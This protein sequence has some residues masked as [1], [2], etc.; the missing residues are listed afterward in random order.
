MRE[1]MDALKSTLLTSIEIVKEFSQTCIDVFSSVGELASTVGGTQVPGAMRLLQ[2][3][4]ETI[5]V[6]FL[7]F[8]VVAITMFTE[9]ATTVK[10][11]VSEVYRAGEIIGAALTLDWDNITD[12]WQQGTIRGEKI[13]AEGAAKIKKLMMETQA[14]IDGVLDHSGANFSNEGRGRKPP[15][16]TGKN[17]TPPAATTPPPPPPKSEVGEW[18]RINKE[19]KDSFEFN[20]DLKTRDLSNDVE[21]WQSKLA[22]A[23]TTNGDLLRV[24]EKLAAARLAVL[25]KETADGKA[26]TEVAIATSEK[27]ALDGLAAAKAA[28]DSEF[29]MGKITQAQ[30]VAL[31]Q[32]AEDQKFQILK[33]HQQLR[34]RL[35]FDDPNHTAAALQREKD[36]LLEIERAHESAVTAIKAKAAIDD[37]KYGKQFEDGMN[38]GFSSVIKNFAQGTMTIQSL[39]L[40]MGK[41]VLSALTDVFAQIAA[42]WL[43][44]KVMQQVGAKVSSMAQIMGSAAAAGAAAFASTAAIPIVGPELAPAAAAAAYSGASSFAA[45]PG[46][47]VG[48]WNI[49]HDMLTKVHAG[50]T[51]LNATDSE[52][53]R[54]ARKG[55]TSSG[56]GD[57]NMNVTI[58]A[59]DGASVQRVFM[60]NSH[61][62]AKEMRRQHRNFA[63]W[64]AS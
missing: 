5:K 27:T 25:K 8:K 3:A 64:N 24:Q 57:G 13:V 37:M 22:L 48:A 17:Y 31:E 36:K 43:A 9:V 46:F 60:E 61:I 38:S 50:E 21:F 10:V 12:A 20:N 29:A 14:E 11:L 41:A 62:L 23:D 59:M 32:D 34:E 52:N 45:M 7:E 28:H 54:N 47:A 33:D 16:K 40:N 30:L 56:E 58:H 55:G 19:A 18:E 44:N 4:M 1:A 2:I 15:P 49:P 42:K 39:F 53:F 6:V 51:I 35:V 26:L 63:F